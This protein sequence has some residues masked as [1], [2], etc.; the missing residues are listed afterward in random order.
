MSSYSQF[1]PTVLPSPFVA[2]DQILTS[3][4]HMSD[5]ALHHSQYRFFLCPKTVTLYPLNILWVLYAYIHHHPEIKRIVYILPHEHS[6]TTIPTEAWVSH[7]LGKTIS[8][9]LSDIAIPYITIPAYHMDDPLRGYHMLYMSLLDDRLITPIRIGHDHLNST[10]HEIFAS[11][12]NSPD[13]IWILCQDIIFWFDD[14]QKPLLWDIS[15][16]S[17]VGQFFEYDDS[18]RKRDGALLHSILSHKTKDPDTSSWS[19]TY[20]GLFGMTARNTHISTTRPIKD[21]KHT[22]L[23]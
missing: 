20:H 17:I 21:K 22:N 4:T 2:A 9:D 7:V 12:D 14:K 10:L 3:L 23:W 5:P 15:K 1:D 8:Y 13:T 19:E 16:T 18:R 6:Q 11:I